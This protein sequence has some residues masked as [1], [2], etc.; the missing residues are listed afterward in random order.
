MDAEIE[1]FLQIRRQCRQ[2]GNAAADMKAAHDHRKPERAELPPEIKRTRILVRLD[3]DQSHHAAAGRA[4][5]LCHCRDIDDGVALVAGFDLDV[6]VGAE[7]AVARALHDQP[8]DAGEAVR[9]QRRAQPL[10]DV[11]I[12]VVMRRLDQD[13]SES[14]L[15]QVTIQTTPPNGTQRPLR[16]SLATLRVGPLICNKYLSSSRHLH[17]LARRL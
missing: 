15:G 4:N 5:A 7:H 12:L 13:D 9:R 17:L 3:A 16:Q 14:A 10:D 2:H 1:R 11:A 8:V 6:D